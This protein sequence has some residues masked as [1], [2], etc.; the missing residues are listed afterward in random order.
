MGKLQNFHHA[1]SYKINHGVS[2]TLHIVE[3][4]QEN[5]YIH[6]HVCVSIHVCMVYEGELMC[7]EQEHY[8]I[9]SIAGQLDFW[10]FFSRISELHFLTNHK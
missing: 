8:S 2:R 6:I 1:L 5:M 4:Q 7:T 3:N 10:T 9:V